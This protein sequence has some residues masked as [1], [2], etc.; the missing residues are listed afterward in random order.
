VNIRSTEVVPADTTLRETERPTGGY[1]ATNLEGTGRWGAEAE[2]GRQMGNE[3]E[4]EV[5]SDGGC[6]GE[7]M[8]SARLGLASSLLR[9]DGGYDGESNLG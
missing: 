5:G 8:G 4:T 3:E 2:A 6:D 7:S 9:D 1:R